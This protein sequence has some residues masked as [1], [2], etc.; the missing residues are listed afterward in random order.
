MY[1]GNSFFRMA[2]FEII[3]HMRIYDHIYDIR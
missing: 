3:Y 2:Y 1:Q